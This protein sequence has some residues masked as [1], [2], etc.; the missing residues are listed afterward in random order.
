VVRIGEKKILQKYGEKV[1]EMIKI[2][3]VPQVKKRAGGGGK[4][5]ADRDV[6]ENRKK[7]KEIR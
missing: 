2:M 1:S 4:R 7:R 5:K 6:G 3:E